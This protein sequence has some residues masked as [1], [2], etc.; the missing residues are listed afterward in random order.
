MRKRRKSRELALQA[1]YAWEMRTGEK[2]SEV[3]ERIAETRSLGPRVRE[4]AVKLVE[5]VGE[6]SAHIDDLIKRHARNWELGRM[7]AIDRNLLRVAVAELLYCEDVP[8]RVVIDEAVEI[9]KEFGTD[10]SG[11]FVNGVMD[12][13]HKNMSTPQEPENRPHRK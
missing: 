5:F 11:K 7:A 2:P 6:N 10:D 13:I 8:Y 4:Y 12:A 1:V 9:A 3:L